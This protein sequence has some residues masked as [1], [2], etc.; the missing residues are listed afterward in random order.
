MFW[1]RSALPDAE[2]A[3]RR[4]WLFDSKGLVVRGRDDLAPHKLAYAHEHDFQRDALPVEVIYVR[5]LDG[6]VGAVF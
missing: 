3:R 5:D 2:E 1:A 4:C 6:A